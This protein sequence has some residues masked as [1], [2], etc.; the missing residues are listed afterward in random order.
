MRNDDN[1]YGYNNDYDSGMLYLME[2]PALRPLGDALVLLKH[3]LLMLGGKLLQWILAM[4]LMLASIMAIGFV[5]TLGLEALGVAEAFRQREMWAL[6]LGLIIVL[7][8]NMLPLV[9]SAGFVSI[10]AGVAEEGEFV[11]SRLFAGFGEPFGQLVKLLLFWLL[12]S[13]A[14]GMLLGIAKLGNSPWVLLPVVV[15]FLLCNW[16]T[17][18]LIMLQGVSPLDAIWMSLVGSLKNIVPLAGFVIAILT[19]VFGIWMAAIKGFASLAQHGSSLTFLL[20]FLIFYT[21]L[22]TVFPIISYVSY[23]NIWTSALLK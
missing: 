14:L 19:I 5:L 11:F 7:F 4:V 17:L 18:P 1:Y 21:A 16:M 10:A 9:F 3:T 8:I 2:Q 20:L 15:M 22:F 12:A 23:R 13:F 6:A